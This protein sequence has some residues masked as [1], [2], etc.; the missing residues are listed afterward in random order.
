MGS[1]SAS[2]LTLSNR[3]RLGEGAAA[4]LHIRSRGAQGAYHDD[5]LAAA[6]F[7]RCL[8]LITREVDRDL[9]VL[10]GGGEV[11]RTPIDHDLA[12]ADPEKSSEIDD[13]GTRLR[14]L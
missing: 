8:Q 2:P 12:A 7:G 1:P 14:P 3:D 9:L 4:R 6:I 13:G 5:G 11:Q 10:S